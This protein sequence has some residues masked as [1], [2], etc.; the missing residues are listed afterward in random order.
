MCKSANGNSKREAVLGAPVPELDYWAQ[1]SSLGNT[2]LRALRGFTE[3]QLATLCDG[4]SSA[5]AEG[6]AGV[7]QVQHL[8]QH[9]AE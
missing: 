2:H 7:V 4:S 1:I 9:L 5:T 6:P 3:P 8:L